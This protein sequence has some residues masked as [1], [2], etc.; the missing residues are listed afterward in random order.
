[1]GQNKGRNFTN[2]T[3]A[4]IEVKMEGGVCLE[5]GKRFFLDINV[6]ILVCNRGVRELVLRL[7]QDIL[8]FKSKFLK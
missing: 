1:M 7:R 8:S 6:S 2:K 3:E 4:E 5:S